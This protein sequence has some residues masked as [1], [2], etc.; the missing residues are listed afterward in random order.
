MENNETT[1]VLINVKTY[2]LCLKCDVEFKPGDEVQQV[3]MLAADTSC[4]HKTILRTMHKA[5]LEKSNG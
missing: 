1:Y 3:T 4:E 5:C 2:S